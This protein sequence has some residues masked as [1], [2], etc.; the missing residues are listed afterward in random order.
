MGKALTRLSIFL[1]AVLVA[2]NVLAWNHAKTIL[3]FS[4]TGK[5][6]GQPATLSLLEK[7]KVALLGV[8]IPRPENTRHPGDLGLAFETCRFPNGNKDT[9]EAWYVP[10]RGQRGMVILFHGYAVSKAFMLPLAKELHTLGY[11]TFLVD[12]YG[13]GGSTGNTTSMGYV[14][15]EDVSASYRFVKKNWPGPPVTLY[16]YS[17]GGA[18]LTRAISAFHIR[19]DGVILESV[20]GKML[21]VARNRLHSLGAP[22]FFAGE[23]F[24][25]WGGIQQGF[26]GFRHN[27]GDYASHVTCPALLL[28]GQQDDRVK[29]SD[30]RTLYHNLKGEKEI[31]IF[32]EAGHDLKLRTDR[33][34]WIESV[35]G[36]LARINEN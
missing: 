17:M 6:T 20:F 36:F 29:A 14:E 1:I 2:V 23:L 19:P 16:G 27:P 11:A 7:L 21:D 35:K 9:L 31:V 13:S 30:A 22:G 10:A 15:A 4:H 18:A 26:N 33:R 3:E 12:F 8:N 24:L 32:K 25:F 28:H 34:L 5:R